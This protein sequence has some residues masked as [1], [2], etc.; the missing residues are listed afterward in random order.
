MPT[1]RLVVLFACEF[2]GLT[3]RA[4]QGGYFLM[5]EGDLQLASHLRQPQEPANGDGDPSKSWFARILFGE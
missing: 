4:N 2:D 1:A 5:V 3:V